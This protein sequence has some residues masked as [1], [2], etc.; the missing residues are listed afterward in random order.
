[1]LSGMRRLSAPIIL[2]M[3]RCMWQALPCSPGMANVGA[4][5]T[6]Y[7]MTCLECCIVPI[8][9]SLVAP[10][11]RCVGYGRVQSSVLRFDLSVLPY[12]LRLIPGP[13][14]SGRPWSV[15][16]SRPRP[17]RS[18]KSCKQ[19]SGVFPVRKGGQSQ[20]MSPPWL[21]LPVGDR[22]VPPA[23][24]S[25]SGPAREARVVAT[26]PTGPSFYREAGPLGTPGL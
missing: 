20:T 13:S 8:W 17:C 23:C 5:N 19:R 12:L 26:S 6:V 14:P 25:V 21:G 1:M 7:V 16:P 24:H 2:F 9:H 3:S 15:V 11:Y 22:I 18:G 4:Y 10:S